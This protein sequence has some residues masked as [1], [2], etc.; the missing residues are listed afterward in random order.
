MSPVADDVAARQVQFLQRA[1]EVPCGAAAPVWFSNVGFLSCLAVGDSAKAERLMREKLT[2]CLSLRQDCSDFLL[3][4]LIRA[5]LLYPDRI[6]PAVLDLIRQ[7][8]LGARYYGGSTPRHPMFY[9]SENHHMSWAV[10]EYLTAQLFAGETFTFDGRPSRAHA[11]RARFLIANW[12]DRRARWG[13]SE[14]NSSPYMGINLM[15]LLNLADFAAESDLRSL[16]TQAVTRLLADLAADSAGGGIWSAQA[17]VYHQ[18]VF[19]SAEQPAAAALMILLGAGDA[20]RLDPT[21]GCGEVFATTRYRAP[22]WLCRLADAAGGDL[23]NEER[24]RKEADLFY[25]CRSAFWRPP[26]ELTNEEAR[27]RFA[28]HSLSDVPIRTERTRDYIV[29]AAMLPVDH[30]L[31][32]IEEQTQFW[33][34]CLG[35]RLPVF[36]GQPPMGGTPKSDGAYWAG[37]GS[38]PRCYLQDGVVAVVYNGGPKARDFTHAH[39]PV[40]QFDD[41]RQRGAWFFGRLGDAYVGLLAPVGAVLVAEGPWAGREIKAAGRQAAWVAVFGTAARDGSFG[42]FEDRCTRAMHVGIAADRSQVEVQAGRV[43]FRVSH[44]AGISVRGEP[45]SCAAWPQ[46]R[47]PVVQSEYGAAVTQITPAGEPATALDFTA[48]QRICSEWERAD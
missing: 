45:F 22:E 5:S 29:S 15:S 10:A 31:S 9:N 21:G 48:A 23:V 12:I 17:R 28:P 44:A 42:G 41:W 11:E 20:G 18:H 1:A 24:H 16:A 8:A 34:G 4:M 39:F 47:N 40:A 19:S 6:S 32:K 33:M 7:A 13:Y 2:Q 35:G 27:Q 25:M 30:A 46:M 37:T 14:W 3:N 38:T 26:F 43:E 36:T